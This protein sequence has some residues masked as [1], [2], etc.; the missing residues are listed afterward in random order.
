MEEI[1]IL[2]TELMAQVESFKKRPTKAAS[3][4]IRVA[5]GNIKKNTPRLR[6]ELVK[7]DRAS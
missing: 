1:E 4:R 2:A 7:R 3:K 5:L 6:A